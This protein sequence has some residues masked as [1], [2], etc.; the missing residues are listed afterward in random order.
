M[1]VVSDFR[2]ADMAAG[3]QGAPLV[4]MLD[5]VMFRS[6]K[7]S[8]VL[9]NLGGIGNLDGGSCGGWCDRRDGVRY[10]TWKYGD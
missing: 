7:V 8:R 1:P 10:R 9:Q 5:Y 4:P 2:P 3:G 6:S